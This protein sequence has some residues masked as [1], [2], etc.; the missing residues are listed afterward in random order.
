MTKISKQNI[1][2]ILQKKIL[3]SGKEQ[4]TMHTQSTSPPSTPSSESRGGLKLFRKAG[5]K[6]V[7]LISLEQT[8]VPRKVQVHDTLHDH[9]FEIA[10]GRDLPLCLE[11]LHS[12]DRLNLMRRENPRALTA[13]VKGTYGIQQ[14]APFDMHFQVNQ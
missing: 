5:M 9:Y 12:Q 1:Q 4:D 11:A 8:L 13:A 6:V 2:T 10:Q 3:P 14:P 7:T